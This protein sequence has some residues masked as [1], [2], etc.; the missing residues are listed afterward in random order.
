MT[1]SPS[2]ISLAAL[3][4]SALGLSAPEDSA[5]SHSAKSIRSASA[6]SESTGPACQSSMTLERSTGETLE[7]L[8]LF[9][10]D[11]PVSRTRSLVTEKASATLETWQEKC[12][13]LHRSM[14]QPGLLGKTSKAILIL[15]WTPCVMVW[16]VR[17]T[18]LGRLVYQLSLLAYQQWNGTS[19]LLPRPQA[20]DSK[21]AGKSR[22][23]ISKMERKNFR[24]VIREASTD[25][26]YPRPEFVEWVKGFPE[27]W[28]ALEPSETPSRQTS[29]KS[30][31]AQS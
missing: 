11:T 29:L 15:G 19:G 3:A 7:T 14:N 28:T 22:Y 5:P 24:E 17:A 10:V 21:G 9:A 31:V 26:I 13:A 6:S 4:D 23:R 20:S 1:C 27:G 12:S 8:T 16:N 2:S 25:G 18:P 30:S